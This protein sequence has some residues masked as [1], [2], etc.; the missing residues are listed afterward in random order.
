[1]GTGCQGCANVWLS[2]MKLAVGEKKRTSASAAPTSSRGFAVRLAPSRRRRSRSRPNSTAA[3][4]S[5]MK[6]N[7]LEGSET[8]IGRM[9]EKHLHIFLFRAGQLGVEFVRIV[10]PYPAR[11]TYRVVVFDTRLVGGAGRR[12]RF[13]RWWGPLNVRS[14]I[15][16]KP[17]LSR[18]GHFPPRSLFPKKAARHAARSPF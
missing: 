10:I 13:G 7:A 2:G 11:S 9:A 18:A 3:A 6:N 14:T 17:D 1:M 5:A 12:W 8:S 4:A 15:A 16:G